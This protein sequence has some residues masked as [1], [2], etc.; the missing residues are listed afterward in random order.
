MDDGDRSPCTLGWR[1]SSVTSSLTSDDVI[2]LGVETV[3]ADISMERSREMAIRQKLFVVNQTK[4]TIQEYSAML[5]RLLYKG[6][7]FQPHANIIP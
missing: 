5:G 7:L 4:N 6:H 2:V 1:L 3:I